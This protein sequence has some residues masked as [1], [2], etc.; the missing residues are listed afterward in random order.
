[1]DIKITKIAAIDLLTEEISAQAAANAH[2]LGYTEQEWSAEIAARGPVAEVMMA[3]DIEGERRLLEENQI[4]DEQELTAEDLAN[5]RPFADV[6]PELAQ[7][8]IR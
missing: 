4:T 6:F 3:Y 1:M 7:R 8:T 2:Q 5:A